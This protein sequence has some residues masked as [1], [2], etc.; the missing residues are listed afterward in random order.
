MTHLP[1]QCPYIVALVKECLRYFTVLR[2]ALPK[3]SIRDIIYEGVVIPAGTVFFLNAWACNMGRLHYKPPPTHLYSCILLDNEVWYDPETFRPERW[4]EH[5]D[6]P[7]FTYGSGYRMCAGWLLANRELYLIFI[8]ML[9]SFEIQKAEDVDC[10]PLRGNLD[11]TSLVSM[12]H[13]Y[14]A[15]FVPRNSKA[16]D[17]AL[18][19]FKAAG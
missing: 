10:H 2:L 14:K 3:A 15:R 16:L 1:E 6:A 12:P 11:P 8:R 18:K 4:L 17:A 19:N 5:P 9:N 13:R 7:M